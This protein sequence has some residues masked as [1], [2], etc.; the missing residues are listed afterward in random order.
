MAR[1]RALPDDLEPQIREFTETLRRLVERSGLGVSAVADRTGYGRTS[2]ERYLD[3][4]L[5]PPRGAVR[6]LAEVT[7]SDLSHLSTL[8]DLAERAWSRAELRHDATREAI[9]VAQ[10]HTTPERSDPRTVHGGWP[11]A[12]H[13]ADGGTDAEPGSR[14][15]P[16]VGRSVGEEEITVRQPVRDAVSTVPQLR[17][18]RSDA[19]PEPAAPTDP[20]E[21]E[22]PRDAPD[23]SS[24]ERST[25]PPA[26]GMAGRE[27]AP[28]DTEPATVTERLSA[29]PSEPLTGE[30]S[31]GQ[32]A[33]DGS[34]VPPR[35][36]ARQTDEPASGAPATGV[37]PTAAD[38]DRSS[39]DVPSAEAPT[40][41]A[42]SGSV[43]ADTPAPLRSEAPA[44]EPPLD[45]LA[46][47]ARSRP[48]GASTSEGG[49]AGASDPVAV[50]PPRP[51]APPSVPPSAAAETARPAPAVPIDPPRPTDRDERN[52]P[53]TGDAPKPAKAP[54]PADPPKPVELAK[55][56]GAPRPETEPVSQPEADRRRAE[57]PLAPPRT[58]RATAP[59]PPLSVPSPVTE[60]VT[61]RLNGPEPAAPQSS[62]DPGGDG[63][64]PGAGP[65]P[66]AGAGSDGG[67]GAGGPGQPAEGRKAAGGGRKTPLLVAGGVA[68]LLVLALAALL[69]LLPGS[70]DDAEADGPP[71]TSP[72]P[73]PSSAPPSDLPAGVECVGESCV[74]QDPERTG[75][76]EQAVTAADATLGQVLVEVR[77]S[78]VCGTSWG[79]VSSASP[80]D[81]LEVRSGERSET[82]R[83]GESGA[84]YTAMVVANA[85]GA[86]VCVT[87]Q[88]G[89]Q[90]CTAPAA[91]TD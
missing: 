7:G 6:A 46:P 70:G 41:D 89:E 63:S 77:Y 15:E 82:S 31:Q 72:T 67:P 45:L 37:P 50:P 22:E 4:L 85:E 65:G 78:A 8:W 91:P 32:G 13:P 62:A 5:L 54:K 81:T 66:G 47:F 36:R 29:P 9:R 57:E 90:G 73:T 68:A 80:G 53:W 24:P 59:P 44:E 42:P 61:A 49:A 30:P 86:R 38:G 10:A 83:A 74:G 16:A 84:G 39:A 71:S 35:P 14:P 28:A 40:G 20:G 19:A 3:G 25:V 1:W 52:G 64:G 33:D 60:P 87:L 12:D 11:R 17:L 2:W 26:L 58:A 18:G 21:P 75:C 48:A 76:G 56:G 43:P 34:G 88:T 23:A 51:S 55:F 69:I 79:R 27:D